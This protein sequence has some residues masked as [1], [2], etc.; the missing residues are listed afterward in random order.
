[1]DA[2]VLT[3]KNIRCNSVQKFVKIVP[4]LLLIYLF[5]MFTQVIKLYKF[6]CLVLNKAD[7]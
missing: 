1:M 6:H 3:G 7:V 4:W 5:D 2:T